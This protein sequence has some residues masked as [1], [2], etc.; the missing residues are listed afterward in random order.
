MP[1]NTIITYLRAALLG[2]ASI[3]KQGILHLD[4]K[5]ENMLF[6]GS[7][8]KIADFGLSRAAKFR[9]RDVEEGDSR[10]LAK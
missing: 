5:P 7:V 3:H 9:S 8:L 4:V 2:L 6:K 10:Y 1:E